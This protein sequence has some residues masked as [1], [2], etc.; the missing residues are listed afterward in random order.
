[1]YGNNFGDAGDL[2]ALHNAVVNADAQSTGV[3]I[4]AYDGQVMFVLNTLNTA[5]TNPTLAAKLQHSDVIGSGYT[6]VTGGGFTAAAAVATAQ[7][8]ALNSDN[9]KKYVRVDFDIGGTDTPAYSV[10]ANII[11]PKKVN[12]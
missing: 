5:G 7:K 8:I 9:L 1:M 2:A 10:S 6:D 3:D 11:G 4:S 12:D